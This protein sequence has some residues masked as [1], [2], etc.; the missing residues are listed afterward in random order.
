MKREFNLNDVP[1]IHVDDPQVGD[2]SI[3]FEDSDVRT[4]LS[5]HGVFSD[6]LTS[7]LTIEEPVDFY[8]PMWKSK[9]PT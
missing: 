2:L 4:P 1:K 6:F 5:L 7:K 8:L 3:C 9:I